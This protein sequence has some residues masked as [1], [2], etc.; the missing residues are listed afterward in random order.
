YGGAFVAE[1]YVAVGAF[2]EEHP[3]DVHPVVASIILGARSLSA[4][5]AFAD[6]YRL[7]DLAAVATAAMAGIDALLLPTVAHVPTIEEVLADPFATNV[8]LGRYTTF[9]N[10]LGMCAVSVPGAPRRDGVP[11]G[12]SVIAR[13]GDDHRALNLASIVEGEPVLAAGAP[14]GRIPLAV[15]GAHLEGQPLHHELTRRDARLVARTS[16]APTYRLH[17]LRTTPPKPGLVR[18]PDGAA[19]E[20]EVWSL[21]ADAFAS[22]VNDVPAPLA[23]G[24]VELADGTWVPG[25]VCEPGALA[26][27][28]DITAFGGWRAYRATCT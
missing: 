3:D 5:D 26:D 1:R 25:F 10:L 22:F 28:V 11:S 20:I 23:I 12:V 24:K 15:V 9:V 21:E 17:A 19:I 6:R 14:D 16:T 4:A 27:A 13:G 2:I 8:A 7:T 18:A